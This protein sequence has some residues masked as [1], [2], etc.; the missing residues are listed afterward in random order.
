[1][2]SPV[3]RRAVACA[4]CLCTCLATG[5]GAAQEGLTQAE[6]EAAKA[7]VS[8]EFLK[9]DGA[10]DLEAVI[11]YF[12]DLYRSDSSI[13]TSKIIVTRP[14]KSRTMEV[15]VWTKGED[16]ALI[17]VQSPAREKGTATLKVDKNLW[18]YMPKIKRTI[19]IPPSMMLGS[20][21]GE[22]LHQRRSGARIIA[23]E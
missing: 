13:S 23:Q 18:N 22:R 10:L 9:E 19:R 2:H 1:M 15:K 17:V 11:S 12:E 20:W 8:S 5:S 3:T 21:M 6:L 14:R 16:N 4:F 7:N